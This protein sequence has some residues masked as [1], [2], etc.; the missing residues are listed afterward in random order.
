[1]RNTANK[2]VLITGGARSGKSAYAQQL[3]AGENRR[4]LFCA[5]AEALDD[6]M[7]T[8]IDAHKRSRPT[9]WDT[10]EAGS[11]VAQELDKIC[12]GYDAILVD[13]ITLLVANCMGDGKPP[14]EAEERALSEIG[15]LIDLMTAKDSNYILVTNEVG[16]GVV[17][18]N[19][20]ARLY[21]D[22]LGRANQK[23]AGCADEVYLMTAG[24][25]LKI[26]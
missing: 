25:P 8:R 13:C 23:L 16:Y 21:R 26:K 14:A 4:V 20:L 6:E 22:V 2:I 1:M 18:E 3:A 7:R 5:T 17:P 10:L 15:A 9:G 11:N 24:L 19:S 12:S